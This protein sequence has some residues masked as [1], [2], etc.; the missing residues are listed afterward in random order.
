MRV[1]S[2]F[3]LRQYDN[4]SL[5]DSTSDS[6]EKLFQ[7]RRGKG[8][9]VCDFGKGG[10]HALRHVFFGRKLL[11]VLWSFCWSWETITIMKDFSAFLGVRRYKN[12]AY[13]ISFW[14]YLTIW[15]PFLQVF[16]EHR[17]LHVWSPPWVPF[18]GYWSQQLQQHM[19]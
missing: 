5:E 4:E 13:K 1:A 8:Q 9:Y 17:V 16:P 2:L 14:E 15:R 11:L 10:V 12:W 7:R 19:I 18:S 6:S 3:Y